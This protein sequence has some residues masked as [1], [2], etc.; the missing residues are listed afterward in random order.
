[1]ENKLINYTKIK[2]YKNYNIIIIIIIIKKKGK[3]KNELKHE[4]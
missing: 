4:K 1:M 3:N 2:I